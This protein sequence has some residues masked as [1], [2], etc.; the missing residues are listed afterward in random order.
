MP[1]KRSVL[2]CCVDCGQA[3]IGAL[4]FPWPLRPRTC[5]DPRPPV[6]TPLGL[7][8]FEETGPVF[9]GCALLGFVP[10]LDWGCAFGGEPGVPFSSRPVRA[11]ALSTTC[12]WRLTL[13]AWLRRAA[14]V[15]PMCPAP[16][17]GEGG[18]WHS[19]Q[20]CSGAPPRWGAQTQH[21]GCSCTATWRS[22][23]IQCLT[24]PLFMPVAPGMCGPTWPC[25]VLHTLFQLWPLGA[26]IW[27]M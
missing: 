23:P 24:S 15:V 19:P 10:R 21:V 25:P 7:T 13:T 2:T 1:H 18:P 14:Q 9:A 22:L 17:R 12:P 26:S 20:G 8:G 3:L 5:R 27:L 4:V 11:H 16:C 6:P